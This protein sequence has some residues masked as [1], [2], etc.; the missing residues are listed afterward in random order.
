M[1][2]LIQQ[3]IPGCK[4]IDKKSGYDRHPS[5]GYCLNLLKIYKLQ[6]KILKKYYTNDNLKIY[7]MYLKNIIKDNDVY[8]YVHTNRSGSN[9]IASYVK[10]IFNELDK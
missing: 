10:Q 9:K 4:F 3:Q 2:I 7:P 5:S 8:D 6:D 1:I